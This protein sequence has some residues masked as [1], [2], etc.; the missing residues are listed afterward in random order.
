MSILCTVSKKLLKS[1]KLR[2]K[3]ISRCQ[4]ISAFRNHRAVLLPV[5]LHHKL[6][7]RISLPGIDARIIHDIKIQRTAFPAVQSVQRSLSVFFR[8]IGF[9][10]VLSPKYIISQR[11]C[12]LSS[13]VKRSTFPAL[14][15]AR[16]ETNFK[17]I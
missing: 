7:L 6:Q 9:E 13:T 11:F 15:S 14:P 1:Y 17:G 3:S 4:K 5:L 12:S 2:L 16:A 8:R 10:I